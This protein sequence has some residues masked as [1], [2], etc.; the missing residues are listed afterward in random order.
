MGKPYCSRSPRDGGIPPSEEPLRQQ[1]AEGR[2]VLRV[3]KAEEASDVAM[4]PSRLLFRSISVPLIVTDQIHRSADLPKERAAEP[5]GV[6][7]SGD[8]VYPP[9]EKAGLK[10]ERCSAAEKRLR[11]AGQ[12]Q[13]RIRL[14]QETRE[15]GVRHIQRGASSIPDEHLADR[16][17]REKHSLASMDLILGQLEGHGLLEHVQGPTPKALQ[18]DV[19]HG[20]GIR[21]VRPDHQ[22]VKDLQRRDCRIPAKAQGGPQGVK[23]LRIFRRQRSQMRSAKE[24]KVGVEAQPQVDVGRRVPCQESQHR[25]NTFQCAAVLHAVVHGRVLDERGVLGIDKRVERA[26]ELLQQRLPSLFRRL[27]QLLR[28]P[29]Q[30]TDAFQQLPLIA[31]GVAHRRWVGTLAKGAGWPRT[32]KR[33][34]STPRRSSPP[35]MPFLLD[36]ARCSLP[37]TLPEPLRS[38]GQ[39]S[40][41]PM[42]L[43]KWLSSVFKRRKWRETPLPFVFPFCGR[44]SLS[45]VHKPQATSHKLLLGLAPERAGADSGDPTVSFPPSPASNGR[46]TEE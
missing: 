5:R 44:W 4:D 14:A 37:T 12:P 43:L 36:A 29:R 2:R 21:Q 16:I 3:A 8:L 6:A 11:M 46:R 24:P 25:G 19:Q 40:K 28:L 38:Q 26:A 9:A 15:E 35:T 41:L 17:H 39:S 27:G 45:A 13:H 30:A 32:L 22:L 42:P 7:Q 10:K 31:G 34:W 20:A 33:S 23:Q 18:P 1:T